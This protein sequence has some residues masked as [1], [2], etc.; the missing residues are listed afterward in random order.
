MGR[1][2]TIGRNFSRWAHPQLIMAPDEWDTVAGGSKLPLAPGG[3][4]ARVDLHG[5]AVFRHPESGHYFMLMMV[6][7]DN[8]D[9]IKGGCESEVQSARC[10]NI[11]NEFVTSR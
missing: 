9:E 8:L 7:F 11:L 4:G 5:G 10:I 1:T 6:Y 2:Q 3:Q